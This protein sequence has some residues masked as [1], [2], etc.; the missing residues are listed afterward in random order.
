[1]RQPDLFAAPPRS[2]ERPPPN[3]TFIRKALGRYL[4][5]LRDAEI[6]PWA[7]HEAISLTQRFPALAQPLP[8]E[9]REALV[10]EFFHHLDRL[11][12]RRAA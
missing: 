9:E 1:M 2:T 6:L 7:E 8:D 3:L 4:R 5:L 11:G 10:A 12:L